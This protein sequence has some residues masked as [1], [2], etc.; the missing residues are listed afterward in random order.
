MDHIGGE[1]FSNGVVIVFFT[2]EVTF[3]QSLEWSQPKRKAWR[4]SFLS[5]GDSYTKP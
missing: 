4:K 2:K 1:P 5:S 3:E